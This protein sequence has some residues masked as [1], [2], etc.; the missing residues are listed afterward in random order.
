MVASC[1]ASRLPNLA[2][3]SKDERE[4]SSNMVLSYMKEQ[5]SDNALVLLSADVML[6]ATK[7][8]LI[9]RGVALTLESFGNVSYPIRSDIVIFSFQQRVTTDSSIWPTNL[10]QFSVVLLLGEKNAFW[11]VKMLV[12]L[13][14]CTISKQTWG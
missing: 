10:N 9:Y 11:L 13:P 8:E 12:L 5:C 7:Y 2:H 1:N 14:F 6:Y 3:H 4:C